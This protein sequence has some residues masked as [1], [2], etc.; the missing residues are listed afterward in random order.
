MIETQLGN[1]N[2]LNLLTHCCYLSSRN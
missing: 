2:V 1:I